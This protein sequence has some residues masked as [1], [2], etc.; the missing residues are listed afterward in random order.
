MSS[1]FAIFAR[2]LWEGQ[3]EM[4]PLPAQTKLIQKILY[5]RKEAAQLLSLSISTLDMLISRGMLASRRIGS[6]R[7]IPHGALIAFAQKNIPLLWIPKSETGGKCVRHAASSKQMPL[8]F[9]KLKALPAENPPERKAIAA[10][11]S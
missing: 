3:N 9:E 10:G 1:V 6:K 7:L 5:S 4:D 11:A 2:H 8:P